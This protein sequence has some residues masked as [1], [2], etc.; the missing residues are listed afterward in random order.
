MTQQEKLLRLLLWLL[1]KAEWI[2]LVKIVAIFAMA[3]ILLQASIVF[4]FDIEQFI[5]GR[6]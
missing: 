5:Y 3:V 4:D 6:F 2:V 1:T